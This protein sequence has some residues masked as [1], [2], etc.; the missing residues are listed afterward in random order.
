MPVRQSVLDTADGRQLEIFEAGPAVGP[1]IVV[2]HGTPGSGLLAPAWVEDAD[3]RGLRLV[4]FSRPGYSRSSRRAGRSVAQVVDD[5]VTVADALGLDQLATWG[6]SGGGPHALA[7]AA[8]LP[9]RV[10][11]ASCISGV[12]PYLSEGLD[13]TEGMGEANVAEFGLATGGNDGRL[14][15]ALEA[16]V[17]VMRTASPEQMVGEMSSILSPEDEATMGGDFGLV[18][19]D[20]MRHGLAQGPFGMF[21]DDLAFVSPW[22]FDPASI[23]VPTQV[24]QG[25][26]DLMV[27]AAHGAW[28]A[29]RIPGAEAHLDPT[30]GHLTVVATRISEV[31]RWLL[32][33]F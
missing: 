31:H 19:V 16:G 7:C 24:W 32:G 8:L 26:A 18:I 9:E 28:L 17:E 20:Q 29:A 15:A 21:D 12:A 30:V 2:H 13:W 33:H 27:P 1:A 3:Q 25:G 5:V 23:Q 14:L 6:I 4:G 10:V 22:G 11:A